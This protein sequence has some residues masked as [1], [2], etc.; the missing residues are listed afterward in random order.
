[1]TRI[2]PEAEEP[3]RNKYVES[4]EDDGASAESSGD[5]ER[6][7][8]ESG[9]GVNENG[10]ALEGGS[11]SDEGSGTSQEGDVNGEDEDEG[12]EIEPNAGSD[13]G[14][15]SG[16]RSNDGAAGD[17]RDEGPPD[18][19]P[20]PRSKKGKVL[21]P[22]DA[23]SV[24]DYNEK[25]RRR[26]V[27]YISRVPPMMKP[28]KM[29]HLLEMH[30]AV[31]RIYL[32]EE[33]ASV[34]KSRK[35]AGGSHGRRYTEGWVEFEDKRVAKA[36]ADSLNNTQIGGRKRDKS[37]EDLWNLKYLKRFKWDHLTE[38]VR[39]RKAGVERK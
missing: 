22:L 14:P 29:K 35:R 12:G 17:A 28:A 19:E 38:K 2:A 21:K 23:K 11:S 32:V 30:G 34:R 1:S 37:R 33:D 7:E 6:S 5:G 9:N 26:G 24:A 18:L 8:G 4:A 13:E 31:T 15:S 3:R 27:V 25:M 16:T 36:V 20:P 10:S 39:R